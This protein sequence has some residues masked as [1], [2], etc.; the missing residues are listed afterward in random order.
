MYKSWQKLRMIFSENPFRGLPRSSFKKHPKKCIKG[1]FKNFPS[2]FLPTF[3]KRFPQK[4]LYGYL[5][6]F[7]WIF[8]QSSSRVFLGFFFLRA[9]VSKKGFSSPRC[10]A[11]RIFSRANLITFSGMLNRDF[12][13]FFFNSI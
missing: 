11:S 4:F 10:Y 3:F 9:R 8:L 7:P 2:T 12:L 5:Q 1:F 13:Y 6:Q